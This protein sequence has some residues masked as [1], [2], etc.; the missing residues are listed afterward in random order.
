[1]HHIWRHAVSSYMMHDIIWCI[2]PLIYDWE[3]LSLYKV[4]NCCFFID[5]WYSPLMILFMN[6]MLTG[7]IMETRQSNK[8]P[9]RLLSYLDWLVLFAKHNW[10]VELSKTNFPQQPLKYYIIPFPVKL[11]GFHLRDFICFT[12]TLF[13]FLTHFCSKLIWFLSNCS[14]CFSIPRC[15]ITGLG[16]LPR[17]GKFS[18]LSGEF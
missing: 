7:I 8:M 5:N 1:M 16:A 17:F 3:L 14:R 15:S 13:Q 11:S 6:G 9:S 10:L 12:I 4:S 2:F 18:S